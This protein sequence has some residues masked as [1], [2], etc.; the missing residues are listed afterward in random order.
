MRFGERL[1]ELREAAGLSQPGL[2]EKTGINVWSIRNWEQGRRAPDWRALLDLSAALGVKAEAFA[3][4]EDGPTDTD[5]PGKAAGS[6]KGKRSG[7]K[8]AEGSIKGKKGTRRR[9]EG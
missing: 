8:A 7:G 5:S 9:K 2:A 4:C 6:P 1:K 3:E